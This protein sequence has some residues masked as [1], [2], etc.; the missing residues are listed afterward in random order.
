LVAS[1]I[2]EEK[3]WPDILDVIDYRQRRN[4]TAYQSHRK[5]TLL[6]HQ[7]H[8]SKPKKPKVS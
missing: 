4:H 8:G 3:C 6:R 7:K 5:R 1:L 2:D